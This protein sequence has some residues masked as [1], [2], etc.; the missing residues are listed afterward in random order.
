MNIISNLDEDK[1]A[2]ENVADYLGSK[3]SALQPAYTQCIIHGYYC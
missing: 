2:I 1:V 3:L